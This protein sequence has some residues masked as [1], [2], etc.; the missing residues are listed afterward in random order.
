MNEMA[1][2]LLIVF[3]CTW[4]AISVVSQNLNAVSRC[5]RKWD[6]FG[7]IPTWTFFAPNPVNRDHY[8]YYRDYSFTNVGSWRR[9]F[10][11]D[12][13]SWY[14]F[15]WSPLRREHKAISDAMFHIIDRAREEGPLRVQFSVSYI[16]I[17]SFVCTLPQER[18]VVAR[19]FLFAGCRAGESPRPIFLSEVHLIGDPSAVLPFVRESLSEFECF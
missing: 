18:D 9:A 19:Q 16:T 6:F 17:L 7:L 12:Q 8:L 10:D 15:L 14:G 2:L 11:A 5:L 13:H 4:A 3:F 1:Q